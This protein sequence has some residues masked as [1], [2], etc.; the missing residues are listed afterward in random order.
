MSEHPQTHAW[1]PMPDLFLAVLNPR[2]LR[3][4]FAEAGRD[5]LP[6]LKLTGCFAMWVFAF[7]F[8]GRLFSLGGMEVFALVFL[9]LMFWFAIL[10]LFTIAR[11]SLWSILP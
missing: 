9:I 7:T 5:T 6:N 1:S 3:R 8:L 2:N 10:A 11:L 4:L